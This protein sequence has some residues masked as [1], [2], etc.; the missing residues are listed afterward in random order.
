MTTSDT[1]A[2]I[3]HFKPDRVIKI[4]RVVASHIGVIVSEVKARF[5]RRRRHRILAQPNYWFEIMKRQRCQGSSFRVCRQSDVSR[6]TLR[7]WKSIFHRESKRMTIQQMARFKLFVPFNAMPKIDFSILFLL[8]TSSSVVCL[9]SMH[10]EHEQT[11]TDSGITSM[12]IDDWMRSTFSLGMVDWSVEGIDTMSTP[13]N[14][15]YAKT[16]QRRKTF[17]H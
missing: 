7:N 14:G 1:V 11:R 16:L 15:T 2:D 4:A 8:S 6:T 5:C 17:L 9:M 3:A 10:N 12:H 13:R